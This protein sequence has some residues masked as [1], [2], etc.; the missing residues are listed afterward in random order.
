MMGATMV[1][2]VLRATFN[3]PIFGTFEVVELALVGIVFLALP[4]VF[5]KDQH[6]TVDVIDQ[7]VAP[8]VVRALKIVAAFL[9]LAFVTLVGWN[10]IGPAADAAKFGETTLDLKLPIWLFWAPMLI[11]MAASFVAVLAFLFRLLA[12]RRNVG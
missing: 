2:V 12:P 8:S 10:M 3:T 5:L 1:D 7:V 4:E 6:V 11:G 9:T